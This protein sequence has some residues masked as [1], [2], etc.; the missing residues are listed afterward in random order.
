MRW[1]KK[2]KEALDAI[3]KIKS[4][5]DIIYQIFRTEKRS[6]WFHFWDIIFDV[7]PSTTTK[8]LY[9]KVMYLLASEKSGKIIEVENGHITNLIEIPDWTIDKIV[10]FKKVMIDNYIYKKFKKI[11]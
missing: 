5:D 1:I 4:Q 11:A 3:E 2:Q 9:N 8:L 10:K 7:I 6:G